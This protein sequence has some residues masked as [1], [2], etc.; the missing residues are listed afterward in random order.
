MYERDIK[1]FLVARTIYED[2]DKYLKENSGNEE[3]LMLLESWR[4]ME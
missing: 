4:E 3:R 2:G 1:E